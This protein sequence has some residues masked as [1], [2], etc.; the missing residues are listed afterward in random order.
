[1]MDNSLRFNGFIS[2][3]AY[4]LMKVISSVC[5]YEGCLW[6]S[7]RYSISSFTGPS[8]ELNTYVID[9]TPPPSVMLNL[10]SLLGLYE[11][12]INIINYCSASRSLPYFCMSLPRFQP[13]C[14]S[15]NL[16]LQLD[17]N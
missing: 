5:W 6:D 1:M 14:F 17:I 7:I 16:N 2:F 11:V 10:V 13:F 3:V 9:K 12:S 8:H 15:L 4:N